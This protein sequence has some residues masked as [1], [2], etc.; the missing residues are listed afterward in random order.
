MIKEPLQFLCFPIN[1]RI[2]LYAIRKPLYFISKSPHHHT[3]VC[4]F[5]ATIAIGTSVH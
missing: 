4:S 3:G 1:L 2:T 5:E